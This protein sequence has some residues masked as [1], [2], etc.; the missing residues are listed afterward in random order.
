M[1]YGTG[2][3]TAQQIADLA[4]DKPLLVGDGAQEKITTDLQWRTTGT[5]AGA[6]DDDADFPAGMAIDRRAVDHTKP[7][8]PTDPHYLVFGNLGSII[9]PFT[10]DM[11]AIIGHN[12]GSLGGQ[13]DVQIADGPLF[14]D[15]TDNMI[16][17]ATFSPGDDG[18][19]IDLTLNSG[20][21]TYTNVDHMR[22][23][24]SGHGGATAPEIGEIYFGTRHQMPH[25][26]QHPWETEDTDGAR[27]A[28]FENDGGDIT[29][30]PRA[31]GRWRLPMT[32]KFPTKANA[33]YLRNFWSDT[34][35]GRK[36]LLVPEPSTTP[37]R[38]YLVGYP[39]GL[40]PPVTRAPRVVRQ[41]LGLLESAPYWTS[42]Q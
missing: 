33:D 36:G 9:T 13:I 21:N 19:L 41:T 22:I 16:T 3:L 8:T 7:A 15:P 10:F 32:M 38:F 14:R 5:S 35:Y 2:A 24:F 28:Y 27:V 1:A 11:V 12:M 40:S 25:W 20:N 42:E 34:A 4:L 18:R 30:Y 29:S 31:G 23:K 17:V 39:G 37:T 6:G 26:P